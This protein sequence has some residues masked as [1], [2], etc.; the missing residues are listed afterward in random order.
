MRDLTSVEAGTMQLL[1]LAS[2]RHGAALTIELL[3]HDL[4]QHTG[5]R[6]SERDVH[7]SCE[8]LR[9][10]H[11]V[12]YCAPDDSTPLSDYPC[13]RLTRAGLETAKVQSTDV[14]SAAAHLLW[15]RSQSR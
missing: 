3:Q 5:L 9:R 10:Q 1:T 7:I 14:W 4:L 2:L 11:L 6:L 13:F 8:M 12:G 15:T